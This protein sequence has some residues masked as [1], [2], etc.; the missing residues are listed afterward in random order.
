MTKQVID[1]IMGGWSTTRVQPNLSNHHPSI[2][3]IFWI[4]TRFVSQVK[5]TSIK[6]MW[7]CHPPYAYIKLQRM[8]SI[9]YS[10]IIPFFSALQNICENLV[11]RI[12]E[13]LKLHLSSILGTRS[14][15]H[16]CNVQ[17]FYVETISIKQ[18]NN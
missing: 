6:Y 12:L 11:E 2:I 8:P 9:M 10:M 4:F 7:N 5:R 1:W 3:C 18:K 14:L 17:I 15:A 13:S 16:F